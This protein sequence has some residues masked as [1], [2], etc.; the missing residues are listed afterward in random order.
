MLLAGDERIVPVVGGRSQAA[1]GGVEGHHAGGH[2]IAGAICVKAAE[3]AV[4]A[5]QEAV[6]PGLRQQ[7]R[8]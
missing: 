6:E 1:D 3:D 7:V 2:R 8:S 4:A 5:G